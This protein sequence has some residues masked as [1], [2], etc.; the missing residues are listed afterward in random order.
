MFRL[1]ERRDKAGDVPELRDKLRGAS[2]L[3]LADSEV[4]P[5]IRLTR[6]EDA[7][8][9]GPMLLDQRPGIDYVTQGAVHRAASGF[10]AEAVYENPLE[11]LRLAREPRL[12]R[13]IVQPGADDITAL[14]TKGHGEV[15]SEESRIRP[16]SR[17]EQ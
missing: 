13:R 9:V 7:N 10:E 2:H 11:R 6:D 4:V 15:L 8:R 3:G 1:F 5:R 17:Q 16:I 14:A 12:E